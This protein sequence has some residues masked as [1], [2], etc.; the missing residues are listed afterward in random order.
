MTCYSITRHDGSVTEVDADE[1]EVTAAGALI[2]LAA[3]G[4]PP[5]G[6]RVELILGPRLWSMV[7]RAGVKII[8]HDPAADPPP[9]PRGPRLLPAIETPDQIADKPW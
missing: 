1:V 4:P 3:D 2:V 7:A 6:L 8:W 5:I 9:P